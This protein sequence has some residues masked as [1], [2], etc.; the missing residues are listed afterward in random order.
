MYVKLNMCVFVFY[1]HALACMYVCHQCVALDSVRQCTC[2]YLHVCLSG[3]KKLQTDFHPSLTTL[4]NQA[5]TCSLW[6]TDLFP[7]YTY[8]GEVLCLILS[9]PLPFSPLFWGWRSEVRTLCVCEQQTT[10]RWL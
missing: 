5:R 4:Q 2:I 3:L 10:Y 6:S 1:A 8:S 7:A 9:P